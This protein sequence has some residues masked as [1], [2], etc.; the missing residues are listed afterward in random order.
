MIK[1]EIDTG[2]ETQY[3]I[4]RA[5]TGVLDLMPYQFILVTDDEDLAQ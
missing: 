2:S 5:I 1:I 4:A 3:E